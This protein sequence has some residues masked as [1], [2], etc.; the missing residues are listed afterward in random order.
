MLSQL[1]YVSV[2][3]SSCTEE[4]IQKILASCKKNN[5]GLDITG[6]LLYSDTNF[7]QYLEGE[8]K[9]IIGLYD[10]IKTDDR[11]KNF[12]LITSSPILERSF[13]SWQ[14]GSKKFNNTDINYQTDMDDSEQ[15][16]FKSIL[17]GQGQEGNKALTLMKKFLK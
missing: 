3:K 4:E 15:Q 7:V 12:V 13:P 8:Y 16:L 10:K 6:V 1:V 2:R 17:S 11:H 9:Q 14:M 5:A